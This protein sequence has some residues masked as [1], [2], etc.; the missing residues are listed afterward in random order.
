MPRI[1]K[2]TVGK[3]GD[4]FLCLIAKTIQSIYPE[5][6]IVRAYSDNFLVLHMKENERNYAVVDQLL[7]Q[8]GLV[9][10][11]QHIEL[12]TNET[13]T[14]EILEDKLLHLENEV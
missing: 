2:N 13:L 12:D 11:Y 4:E 1:I 7:S 10:Q 3:K 8:Y 6:I 14:L 5:A 9:M